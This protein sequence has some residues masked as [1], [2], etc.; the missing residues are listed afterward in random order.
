M[1][2]VFL[3][4]GHEIK[5]GGA[6]TGAKTI[7]GNEAALVRMLVTDIACS[8]YEKYKIMAITDKDHW[9][10]VYVVGWLKNLVKKDDI[11]IDFH[12]NAFHLESANGTEAFIPDK[13]TTAEKLLANDI[14]NAITDAIG[15]SK[16]NPPVKT[17]SQSQH[18]RLAIL[19][20][21][22]LAV[23]VLVEICF[24]SNPNDMAAFFDME[25]YS[26]MIDNLV[27]VIHC[28]WLEEQ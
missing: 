4:A 19:S 5:E 9:S 1:K 20:T 28:H 22:T 27:E 7:H 12:F 10:L 13:H 14:V 23:N 2:K 17:E 25:K 3:T 24:L 21:P 15:T 11:I 26:K 6:T 8:L 18:P 16:R